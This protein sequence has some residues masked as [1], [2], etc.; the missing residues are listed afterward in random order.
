[1]LRE[2]SSET[3]SGTAVGLC[4]RWF[5]TVLWQKKAVFR[6]DAVGLRELSELQLQVVADLR[7]A[8]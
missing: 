2:D 1:M 4:G 5:R 7:S 3:L 8:T 6:E